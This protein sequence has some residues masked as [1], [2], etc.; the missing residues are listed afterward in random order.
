MYVFIFLKLE[1]YWDKSNVHFQN[2]KT[3]SKFTL[4]NFEFLM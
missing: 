3:F 1:E 2:L 4:E